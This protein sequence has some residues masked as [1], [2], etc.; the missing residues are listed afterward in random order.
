MPRAKTLLS[1]LRSAPRDRQRLLIENAALR[2]QVVVLKRSVP[3]PRLEDSD[4]IFWIAM[5]RLVREWQE[6][7]LIVKPETVVKWHRRGFRFSWARRSRPR[8]TGRPSI[9][10]KLVYLI[11][12]LSTE[13]TLWGAPAIARELRRL[14]H[15]AAD[16][17]VAK[18]MVPRRDPGRGQQWTTFLKNH[19]GVTAAC[20]FF[21]V[22]TLR[23][24]LL[25]GFAVLSHDRRRIVHVGVTAHPTA[26]WTA[27]QLVEAFPGDEEV[28]RFLV[29]DRDAIYGDTFERQVKAMGL[30][31]LR[32][33]H[34]SPWQTAYVE[35]VIGSIRRECLDHIIPLGERHLL[36]TLRSYADWYNTARTHSGSSP[37]CVPRR[38]W[39]IRLRIAGW[40]STPP[41]AANPETSART[42]VLG[43]PA[44]PTGVAPRHR[45]A[46]ASRLGPGPGRSDDHA[47]PHPRPSI[48]APTCSG[49]LPTR[50][51]MGIDDPVRRLATTS[52][53]LG[54]EWVLGR[55]SL[56][57]A[58]LAMHRVS[59]N[60]YGHG[61]GSIPQQPSRAMPDI[62]DNLM[63]DTASCVNVDHHY[64]EV[65]VRHTV[66]Q[67]CIE[68]L[69]RAG[70]KPLHRYEEC[71]L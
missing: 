56:R 48:T 43:H 71:D 67:L 37:R 62:V 18:Y 16:S 53:Q 42:S 55:H 39:S 69:D 40:S 32:T 20:D 45:S 60:A 13:N 3:R 4:R 47:A 15:Q 59:R 27:R 28:P 58:L 5:R 64:T 1:L 51:G 57:G 54:V 14:G 6:C 12:R 41:P 46:P 30:R 17:K 23:F 11:K 33:A 50:R 21:V 19:L 34:R 8:R 9:G 24:S 63:D 29:R 65:Q 35:R 70:T 36:R 44:Q 26:E 61:R 25:Y 52:C 10:W 31:Q 38:A 49:T 7:L 66:P 22:P 2:H 68:A